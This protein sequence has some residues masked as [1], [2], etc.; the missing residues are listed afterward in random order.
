MADGVRRPS[1][2]GYWV[3]GVV[4]LAGAIGAIVWLADSLVG[5][6]TLPD[7]FDRV[8]VP[9]ETAVR[10]DEGQHTL[11]AEGRGTTGSARPAPR[12]EVIA[13]DGTP[14]PLRA[15][16]TT[17]TYTVGRR[18]GTAFAEFTAERE[19]PHTIRAFG[20]PGG[21]QVAVGTLFDLGALRGIVGAVV[22]GAVSFLVALIVFVVTLVRRSRAARAV[23]APVVGPPGGGSLAH[24]SGPGWGAA[25]GWGSPPS[26]TGAP[27]PSCGPPPDSL[28]PRT[29]PGWDPAPPLPPPA[30]SPPSS[31]PASSPSAPE[32]PPG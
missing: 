14:V 31:P 11:W 17:R 23:G 7:G 26:P 12:V 21:Q 16:A 32:P 4:F 28:P 8:P 10:L 29:P 19:G 2:A 15:P 24:G 6:F 13:P 22:V 5:A 18:R 3:A 9:G 20:E 25:P 30:P 1:A 27:S